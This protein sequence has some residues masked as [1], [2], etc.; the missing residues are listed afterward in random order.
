M[1]ASSAIVGQDY[2]YAHGRIG[3]LQQLLL[4]QSDIDRLLGTH[5]LKELQRVLTELKLTNKID[6]GVAD[7][8]A[9]LLS[10]GGWIRTEVEHMASEESHDIFSILWLEGDGP[11]IAYLLKKRLGMTSAISQEPVSALHAWDQD[12]LRD[13]VLKDNHHTL[14][15]DEINAF[16]QETAA[17][18]DLSPEMIDTRTAQ[19]IAGMRLKMAKQSGSTAIRMYVRHQ[20]DQQNIRTAMRTQQTP[21]EER[22]KFFINGGTI[23]VKDLTGDRKHLATVIRNAD[24]GYGLADA[25]EKNADA[26]TLE[27][28]LSDILAE[29]I[30]VMWNIPLRV[31]PLFAFAALALSHVRL[32]RVITIGKASRLSPQEIKKMLPPFIPATHYVL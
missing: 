26:N 19:F 31:E 16:V 12:R 13:L 21:E 23:K 15:P 4:S 9:I 3:V 17:M 6:Q 20:I 5:D 25:V 24:L 8:D 14:L 27:R 1:S 10:L 18:H 29:D 32:L 28:A 2:A 22:K 11:L 30:A 7:R